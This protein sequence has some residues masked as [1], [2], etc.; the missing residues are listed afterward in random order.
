MTE[1]KRFTDAGTPTF[2]QLAAAAPSATRATQALGPFADSAE[3]ALLSL[4]DAAE[5]SQSPLVRSDSLIRQIRKLANSAAPATSELA[6]FLRSTRRHNGFE[7]L[8]QFAY[9]ATGAFNAFD[10]LGHFGRAFLLIT[11]CNDYVTDQL[12]FDCIANFK[13]PTE[14][15]DDQGREG[16]AQ[17]RPGRA[18]AGRPGPRHRRRR[19]GLGR[20]R[21]AAFRAAERAAAARDDDA[22][23]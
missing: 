19:A 2:T 14:T 11:N 21:A 15:E 16:Q 22:G 8:L 9:Q 18:P 17:A 20:V 1:L 23:G 13:E 10:D 5:A 7:N 12:L 6:K 4:G 3:T